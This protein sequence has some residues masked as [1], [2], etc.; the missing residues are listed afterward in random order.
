MNI[1][2]LRVFAA[3]AGEGSFTAAARRLKI[4]QPAVSK[5]VAELEA[6]VDLLLFERLPR[7]VRMTEAGVVLAEHTQRIFTAEAAAEADLMAM[8][9]ATR[10]RLRVGAS[11]TIG[12]Y[13]IPK[14]FGAFRSEH[15]DVA[16]ELQ[17]ANTEVIQRSLLSGE[18]D[19]ALT[20]GFVRSPALEVATV[21][22]D[23]LV[24][25]A[26]PEH[27]WAKTPSVSVS[28]SQLAAEPFIVREHGSGTRDVI[29]A[30]LRRRGIAL[31]PV[32]TLG[33]TEAIKSAVMAGL[34]VAMVSRLTVGLELSSARL[35][36]VQTPGFTVR[37]ALHLLLREQCR[38]SPVAQAFLA[39]LRS[40]L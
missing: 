6:A 38:P 9:G 12:S 19:L 33:S 27:P 20:E 36:V 23:E 4:S 10:G 3:V 8:A 21:H 30:A 11:T 14:L 17:I 31:E 24:V 35:V 5:Q 39:L 25:I 2:H 28:L 1:H 26:G 29:E 40:L 32:M 13:L 16:L 34:G 15:P 7:G 37:R 18:L 22:T